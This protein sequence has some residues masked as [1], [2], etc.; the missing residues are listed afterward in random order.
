MRQSDKDTAH[1]VHA[2]VREIKEND[3]RMLLK[4]IARQKTLSEILMDLQPVKSARAPA[5][6]RTPSASG[7]PAENLTVEEMLENRQK[8][9]EEKF[10]K[11]KEKNSANMISLVISP[12]RRRRHSLRIRSTSN[13]T[14]LSRFNS[15]G[16]YQICISDESS[17]CP[18]ISHFFKKFTFDHIVTSLNKRAPQIHH[19]TPMNERGCCG[20][21]V[22]PAPECARAL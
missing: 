4:G 21:V 5:H 6:R 7:A 20:V 11:E 22:F 13:E 8:F 19:V 3:S 15:R 17:I 16:S 1:E 9:E 14:D 18:M 2:I 12:E 10:L